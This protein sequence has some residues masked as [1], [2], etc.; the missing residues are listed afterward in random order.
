VAQ[1]AQPPFDQLY[2]P[3]APALTAAALGVP[4]VFNAAEYFIDRHVAE[5]RGAHVAIECGDA[6]VTYADLLERVNRFGSALRDGLEI[7][8]EDR[9]VLLLLDGPAFTISFFGSIKIGAVP[10]P[11]NTLWKAADYRYALADS[12]ARMVVVSRELLP[13]LE[14]IPRSD[15]PA[16]RH[17]VV[18]DQGGGFDALLQRGSSS[19]DAHAGS[20]DAPSVRRT[21]RGKQGRRKGCAPAARRPPAS[22]AAVHRGDRL[23]CLLFSPTGWNGLLPRRRD[24]LLS[25]AAAGA[26]LTIERY[27]PT[28]P[29][30]C[31]PAPLLAQ[32][33]GI[34]SLVHPPGGIGG[35]SPAARPTTRQ[36]FDRTSTDRSTEALHSSSEPAR[37]EPSKT[38]GVIVDGYDARIL[39]ARVFR[40]RGSAICGSAEI[41]PASTLESARKPGHLPG[42]WLRTG[43]TLTGRRRFS[44]TRAVPTTC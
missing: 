29:S 41:R 23:A 17:V 38:S 39:D 32:D 31:R 40:W 28:L 20:H 7:R 11:L 44:A 9:V 1:A 4:E 14:K 10:I 16:L 8:P 36:R 6:Q 26:R 22:R 42:E 27:R 33:G 37:S 18:V 24:Q 13:E 3:M 43:D 15:L 21:R 35:R 12:A 5:G 25:A 2:R 19:L 30:R 34:R